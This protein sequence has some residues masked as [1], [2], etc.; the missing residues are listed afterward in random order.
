VISFNA[1]RENTLSNKE[2]LDLWSSIWIGGEV[3]KKYSGDILECC[4]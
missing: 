4:S 3:I 2:L 1:A